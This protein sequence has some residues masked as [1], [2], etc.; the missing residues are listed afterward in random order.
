[1]DEPKLKVPLRVDGWKWVM[2]DLSDGDQWGWHIRIPD[3]ASDPEDGEDYDPEKF[4]I[5][6]LAPNPDS[7]V[8][9]DHTT[10]WTAYGESESGGGMMMLDAVGWIAGPTPEGVLKVVEDWILLNDTTFYK[11]ARAHLLT[12][13]Y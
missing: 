4:D 13:G 1:M 3:P 12:P 5:Y 8:E 7:P 9:G 11:R 2:F 10:M 6:V